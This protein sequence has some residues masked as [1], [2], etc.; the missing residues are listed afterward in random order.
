MSDTTWPA[1]SIR[2]KRWLIAA[3]VMACAGM[4]SMAAVL[5]YGFTVGNFFEEGRQ[6]LRM[7]WGVVSL[8]DV[9]VGFLLFCCWVTFRERSW[10][11]SAVWTLLVLTLGNLVACIYLTLVLSQTRGNWR[12]FW[13]G[14][15]P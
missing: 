12:M 15:R 6:L 8:V 5:T 9:Y 11:R 1:Q 7:P 2:G 13:L 4:V 3:W 10:W 14:H